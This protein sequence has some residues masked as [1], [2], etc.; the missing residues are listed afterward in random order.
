MCKGQQAELIDTHR[1]YSLNASTDP[2][3]CRGKHKVNVKFLLYSQHNSEILN[4]P[5]NLLL[6]KII[7]ITGNLSPCMKTSSAKK[8]I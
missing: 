7:P 5:M 1:K 6:S 2:S 3:Q 4:N 8:I